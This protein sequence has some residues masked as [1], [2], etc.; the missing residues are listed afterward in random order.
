MNIEKELLEY[1]RQSI[2]E[3]R[4]KNRMISI[5]C[6]TPEKQKT[7]ILN[8]IR[9]ATSIKYF[10]KNNR[11]LFTMSIDVLGQ[12]YDDIVTIIKYI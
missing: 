11:V 9:N 10:T 2:I 3:W 12:H 4:K 8:Q 6:Y 1:K 7:D 5:S